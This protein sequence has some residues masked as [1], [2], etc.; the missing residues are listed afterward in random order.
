M[1]QCRPGPVFQCVIEGMVVVY[2]YTKFE[3]K[4]F[5]EEISIH[6]IWILYMDH[7]RADVDYDFNY[8]TRDVCPT[9]GLLKLK[10]ASFFT[11]E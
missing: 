2:K 6:C 7:V 1:S 5:E 9:S 8:S 10:M 4:I 3:P 11:D